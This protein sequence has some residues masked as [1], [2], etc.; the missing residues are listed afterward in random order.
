MRSTFS[1]SYALRKNRVSKD[2]QSTIDLSICINNNRVRLTTGKKVSPANWDAIKQRVRGNSE[3]ALLLNEYLES[4]KYKLLQCEIDLVNH[5]FN[6]TPEL[7]KDAY[8][9]NVEMLKEK[10]LMDVFI[11]HNTQQQAM[12][13]KGISK[14]TY[15]V[16]E[17]ILRLITDFLKKR[18]KRND[19]YLIRET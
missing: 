6:V 17:H 10:S 5:G 2:G 1:V 8:L 16:S 13:G 14:A 3:Q 9:N 7:L 19:I 18:Y 15:F 12:V 11:E 4:I